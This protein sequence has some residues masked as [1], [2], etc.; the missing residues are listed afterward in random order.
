MTQQ[1]LRQA[2]RAAVVDEVA[3]AIEKSHERNY[4]KLHV[5]RDGSVSWREYI[6]RSDDTIDRRAAGFAAVPSVA[7]VGTGS[8]PCD[9]DWCADGGTVDLREMDGAEIDAVEQGMLTEFAD[10]PA[11][12]FDDEVSV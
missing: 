8:M 11:G 7:C 1:T 12:Y 10:I 6:N 5:W 4:E 9:C 2:A 3:N